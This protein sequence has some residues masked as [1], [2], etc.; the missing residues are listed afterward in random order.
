MKVFPETRLAV[1][2]NKL[3]IYVYIDIDINHVFSQTNIV[4]NS[5]IFISYIPQWY[6]IIKM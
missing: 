4:F 3:Y 6:L 5:I 1:M 2:R